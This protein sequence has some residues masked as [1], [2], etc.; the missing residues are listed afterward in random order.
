MLPLW[1]RKQRIDTSWLL[2]L[3]WQNLIG[4]LE[5][6]FNI[7]TLLKDSGSIEEYVETP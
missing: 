5:T 4:T 6:Y 2:T 7:L 1:N 3:H